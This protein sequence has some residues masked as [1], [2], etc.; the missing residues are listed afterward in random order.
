MTVHATVLTVTII[1]E[2]D[3]NGIADAGIR[4]IGIISRIVEIA[5]R[6]TEM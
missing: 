1:K 5:Y 6:S 3:R 4:G 2:A